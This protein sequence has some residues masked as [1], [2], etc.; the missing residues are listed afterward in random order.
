[1]TEVGE[2]A[3]RQRAILALVRKQPIASQDA[4]AA[5]LAENGC[6]V[7]QS[8]LSRD[9]KELRVLRVPT[10]SG[11]R[12]HPANDESG[13]S[14]T[15]VGIGS[16]APA[17]V[18]SVEANESAVVVRT[19]V[20]RAQGVAVY[21]DD[22]GQEDVLGTIAGDDTILVLP[23]SVKKTVQLRD[24]LSGLFG[25]GRQRGPGGSPSNG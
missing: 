18:L 9:L 4:L 16:L 5:A 20:G 25:L 6:R 13:R 21:L 8:T 23:S 22:L 12:Y 15:P 1:M 11:Y 14:P 3:R 17:E 2:K 24:R 7:T 19:L 10:D